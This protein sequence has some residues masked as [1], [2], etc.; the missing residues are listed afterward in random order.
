[1]VVT[2]FRD[3]ILNNLDEEE[4]ME[5]NMWPMESH[6]SPNYGAKDHITYVC[7][8]FFADVVMCSVYHV[9]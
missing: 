2:C 1:M 8:W 9:G 6:N 5:N 4:F 7:A 3:F